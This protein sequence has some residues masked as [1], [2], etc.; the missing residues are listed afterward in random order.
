LPPGEEA[1]PGA[2]Q[3]E[4]LDRGAFAAAAHPPSDRIRTRWRTSR[5][6]T[7]ERVTVRLRP[8]GSAAKHNRSSCCPLATRKQFTVSMTSQSRPE[9]RCS[10]QSTWCGRI[11][12]GGLGRPPGPSCRTRYQATAPARRSHTRLIRLVVLFDPPQDVLHALE[13]SWQVRVATQKLH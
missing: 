12:S 6:N 2:V 1:L 7:R 13:Q 10:S 8:A 4:C 9:I 11:R 3:R 5:A